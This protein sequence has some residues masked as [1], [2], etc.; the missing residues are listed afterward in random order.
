MAWVIGEISVGPPLGV[1]PVG[2]MHLRI[3]N[4]QAN[5]YIHTYGHHVFH[6]YQA[7]DGGSNG[8]RYQGVNDERFASGTNVSVHQ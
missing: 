1:D 7:V 8:A 2:Q 4:K 6:T 5:T 3:Q